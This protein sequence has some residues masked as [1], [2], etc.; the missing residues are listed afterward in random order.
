MIEHPRKSF[1]RDD[2][3]PAPCEIHESK[4]PP[5][6]ERQRKLGERIKPVRRITPPRQRAHGSARNDI[7]FK[8][9]LHQP[10]ENTNMRK[11]ARR[12]SPQGQPDGWPRGFGKGLRRVAALVCQKVSRHLA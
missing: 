12:P 8:A 9:C 10:R 7:W 4:D 3:S 6:V 1:A 5:P 11:A 2:A